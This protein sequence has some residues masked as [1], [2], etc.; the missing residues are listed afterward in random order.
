MLYFMHHQYSSMFYYRSIIPKRNNLLVCCLHA[1]SAQL[2]LIIA[3]NQLIPIHSTKK[4][5]DTALSNAYQRAYVQIRTY[6]ILSLTAE[7]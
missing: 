7:A 6:S 1:P 5:T 2:Y 3:K 4:D